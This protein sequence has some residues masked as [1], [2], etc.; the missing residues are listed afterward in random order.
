MNASAEN[1]LPI[2]PAGNPL[3]GSERWEG[4]EIERLYQQ[5]LLALDGMEPQVAPAPAASDACLSDG[6]VSQP[7]AAAE[8]PNAVFDSCPPLLSPNAGTATAEVPAQTETSAP[9]VLEAALFVGGAP[10]TAKRLAGLLQGSA[11]AAQVDEMIGALNAQYAV[12]ARPYEIRL[13][14]GGYRFALRQPFE[15]VRNRVYGTA[16]REVKL[17]HEVLE[18]LALVAYKQPVTRADLEN[19]GRTNMPSILRQLLRRELISLD[20][21]GGPFTYRTT[22]RF[23]TLFGLGSL[24]ELPQAEDVEYK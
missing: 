13:A 2:P 3:A 8:E 20:R 1:E 6:A 4:D 10:L 5:A 17:S 12:E 19:T 11:D 16:P 9:Q 24:E 18:I 14:E 22:P 21:G 15:S 7:A 23:L